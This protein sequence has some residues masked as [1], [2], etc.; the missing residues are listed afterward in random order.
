MGMLFY[1]SFLVFSFSTFSLLVSRFSFFSSCF[2]FFYLLF[3]ISNIIINKHLRWVFFFLFDIIFHFFI[4]N[5]VFNKHLRWILFFLFDINHT[6]LNGFTLI[7]CLISF[8]F[9]SAFPYPV[10]DFIIILF[11]LNI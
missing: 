9:N 8:F 4:S 5:I 1:F 7:Y 6:L 10:N 3:I 2:S 11:L